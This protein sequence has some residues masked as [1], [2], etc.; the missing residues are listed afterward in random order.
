MSAVGVTPGRVLRSEWIKL[1]TLRSTKITFAAAVALMV[2]FGIL[3]CWDT[4]RGFE[5]M[6]ASARADF[7]V[8]ERALGGRMFAELAIGVLGVMAITGEYATGMIRA[9][10]AAVPR[11]LPVLWTKL[12]LFAGVTFAVMTTASFVSFFAG[13]AI[14]SEHWDFSLSDPGVL[15]S[16]IGV[17]VVLTFVCLFG[18]ALGFIVRNTAG[19]ISTLFA[20]L[21][22]LPIVAQFS[23]W[24]SAHLPTGAMH[25]LVRARIEDGMLRPLPAFL[26]LCAYLAVAIAGAVWTLLRRDA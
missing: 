4:V 26:L 17:G 18:T 20:I 12:G 3:I 8:T 10:L 6:A 5:S 16:V 9:T 21:M 24:V 19:A 22:V 2:G 15:R 13:N 23:E 14:L 11:R 7:D 1:N 25:S